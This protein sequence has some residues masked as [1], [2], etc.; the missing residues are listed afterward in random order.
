M[1]AA[2]KEVKTLAGKVIVRV[3]LLDNSQKTL[4]VEPTTTVQVRVDRGTHAS[5]GIDPDFARRLGLASD[6]WAHDR[7][8]RE[9][10]AVS[11]AS[12]RTS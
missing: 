6:S 4:L 9:P 2:G 8:P 1:A 10:C 12:G 3:N 11:R 7:P 5:C